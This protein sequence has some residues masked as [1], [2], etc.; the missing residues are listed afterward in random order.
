MASGFEGYIWAY[1]KSRLGN[2]F[3][4]AGLMG[5]L[6]AES[7]LYPNR[8]Q[9]DIPYSNRS[10]EYTAKVDSGAISEYD[11]V[12]NGPGGGGYGLAQWTY[13]SRKQALYDMYKSGGYPSIGNI[14][15]AC[16][17]LWYELSHSYKGVLQVLM[18]ATS[19]REASD[20]VLHDFENPANQSEAVEVSRSHMGQTFYNTYHGTSGDVDFTQFDIWVSDAIEWAVSIANDN[21]HGYDQ[22]H[23]WGPDYDCSSLL[24]T[25]FD[26]AGCPV[27][28][29]GATRS[30]NMQGAWEKTGG[31]TLEFYDTLPLV[32]GDILWREG[33]VGMYIGDSK[34]V[35]A[36]S[37]ENGEVTGGQTG[38][39]TGHEIDVSSL[40]QTMEWND[41]K[42][43]FRFPTTG[44]IIPRKRGMSKLL[45][46]AMATDRF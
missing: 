35:S 15:L 43:V 33:H 46:F 5:N 27:K 11:F 2:E 28:E 39:Q 4:T 13:E 32:R 22:E 24:I 44:I 12:H 10:V 7:G 9:G 34:V 40:A 23:R 31:V 19:V 14:T 30:S 17:Y 45:L 20:K 38:D 8:L 41:W 3:G 25:A 36:H 16:D 29:N 1:F 21:T 26:R 6:K 37:N 42:R 18:G